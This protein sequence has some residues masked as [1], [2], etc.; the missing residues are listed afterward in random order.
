MKQGA[1]RR[2]FYPAWAFWRRVFLC[3]R[4]GRRVWLRASDAGWE[5]L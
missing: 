2:A 1:K 4:A 3:Q 5:V